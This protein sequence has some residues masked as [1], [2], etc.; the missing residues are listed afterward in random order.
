MLV[1]DPRNERSPT[2]MTQPRPR[3]LIVD[4]EE[5]VRNIFERVLRTEG[6]DVRAVATATAALDVVDEWR[7]DA[8]LL[9][10]RMP[11]VNGL[12]FLYRLREH[13]TASGTPVAVITG[14]GDTKGALSTECAT[15]GVSVYFKPIQP[16]A[17]RHIARTLLTSGG[18]ARRSAP[19][20]WTIR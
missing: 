6:Y 7:P 15:L 1:T 16:D 11:L 3:F 17:L 14:V 8:I 19:A 5:P 9:D 10:Y 20:R 4:D 12:G 13:E 2:E 18:D